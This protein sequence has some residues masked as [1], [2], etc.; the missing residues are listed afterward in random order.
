MLRI[1]KDV[2]LKRD[3]LELL[4]NHTG[5]IYFYE[6][7]V[8]FPQISLSTLQ[9][10]CHELQQEVSQCYPNQEIQILIDKRNGIELIRE[11]DNLQ[12]IT[13]FLMTKELP[14][15][16]VKEF[17]FFDILDTEAF[18]TKLEISNSQLRR[19]ISMMNGI[20]NGYDLHMTVSHQIKLFGNE[21]MRRS[22]GISTLS[23]SHRQFSEIDWVDN[24]DFYI[25]QA[26]KIAEYL[27]L[28]PSHSYLE[29]IALTSFVNEQSIKRSRRILFQQE[30]KNLIQL[31][32]FPKKPYFLMHW[33]DNDWIYLLLTMYGASFSEI[34]LVVDESL[35]SSF[36]SSSLYLDW[37]ILFQTYFIPLKKEQEAQIYHDL[38]RQYLT[39]S[40]LKINYAFS[41]PYTLNTLKNI[42]VYH[43]RY[44][45]VFS[46]F[47][48]DFSRRHP[49]FD[50]VHVQVSNLIT[51]QSLVP[52][53]YYLPE[54]KLFID[55]HLIDS[56][57]KMMA[58]RITNALSSKYK[59]HFTKN[60]EESDFV[61][62][63]YNTTSLFSKDKDSI[64]LLEPSLSSNDLSI[65]E[66]KF[67]AFY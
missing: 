57:E 23:L 40:L 39:L 30:A 49:L 10:K 34:P 61:I 18:C 3:I 1:T 55:T 37:K 8:N 22:L 21:I 16:I 4:D 28:P 36:L 29:N 50:T 31:I 66:K 54:V 52:W 58:S 11:A 27:Q 12:K 24:S 9:K 53:D 67:D 42:E 51:C 44:F 13:E 62:T 35:K 14:Y 59:I 33:E 60:E 2:W 63:T 19:K 56:L 25:N 47:W 65:L 32:H 20:I 41:S 5:P 38:L 43:M 45:H 17:I 64:I 46:K 6:V 26:T 15:Q 7:L 48:E